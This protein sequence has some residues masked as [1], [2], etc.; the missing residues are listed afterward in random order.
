MAAQTPV[1]NSTYDSVFGNLRAQVV[2][3]ANIRMVQR[4]NRSRLAL[5]ALFQFGRRRKMRGQNFD[6]YG[7]IEAGV[8]GTVDLSHAA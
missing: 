6:G 2:K 5:H 8:E 3:L 4:R 1:A 7:A